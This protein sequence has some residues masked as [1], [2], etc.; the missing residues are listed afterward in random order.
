MFD[1]RKYAKIVEAISVINTTSENEECCKKSVSRHWGRICWRIDH[2]GQISVA[3]EIVATRIPYDTNHNAGSNA[4]KI[5][6]DHFSA[7]LYM[8]FG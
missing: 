4:C 8:H 1:P 5:T 7:S 3:D 2:P 6:Y